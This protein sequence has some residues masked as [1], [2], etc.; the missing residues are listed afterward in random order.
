M[1]LPEWILS[2]LPE[3]SASG[4][5]L[6]ESDYKKQKEIGDF[7]YKTFIEKWKEQEEI[8]EEENDLPP[9]FFMNFYD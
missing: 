9:D 5:R 6:F 3:E 7:F 8:F 2:I 4:I 1:L